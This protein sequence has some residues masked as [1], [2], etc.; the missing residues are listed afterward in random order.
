MLHFTW[1]Y[2]KAG[3][4]LV[5]LQGIGAGSLSQFVHLFMQLQQVLVS[6]YVDGPL[7]TAAA[8]VMPLMS[9]HTVE[10]KC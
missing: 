4:Y 1:E 6:I 7:R 3:F 10:L 5:G 8:N 9:Q 2:M